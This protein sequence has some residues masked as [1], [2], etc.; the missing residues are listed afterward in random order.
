MVF[1]VKEYL[2][3]FF[4]ANRPVVF[5]NGEGKTRATINICIFDILWIF[6]AT[7]Q[8]WINNVLVQLDVFV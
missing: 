3:T 6:A 2:E 7:I 1:W 4:P 5:F 8:C